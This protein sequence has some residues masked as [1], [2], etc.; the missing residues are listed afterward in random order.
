MWAI[1]LFPDITMGAKN[2]WSF[3]RI[4]TLRM[5]VYFFGH[6]EGAGISLDQIPPIYI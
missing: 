6:Y 3:L 2:L 4:K 5:N 1:F